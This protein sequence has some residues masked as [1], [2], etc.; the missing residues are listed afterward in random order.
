MI[1]LHCTG[2]LLEV[3]NYVGMSILY[4]KLINGV[5]HNDDDL[6]QST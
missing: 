4:R 2:V 5:F 3:I 1:M 6:K